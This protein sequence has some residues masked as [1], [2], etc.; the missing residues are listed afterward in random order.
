MKTTRD[1]EGLPLQPDEALLSTR[2]SQED[3]SPPIGSGTSGRIRWL[4]E[5]QLEKLFVDAAAWECLY[6]DP[7]DGRLWCLSYPQAAL[8]GGGPPQLELVSPSDAAT[9]F[10]GWAPSTQG[11]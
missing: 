6:R 5:T 10:P 2:P 7:R 8:P 4:V 9:R 3:K 11:S 1:P